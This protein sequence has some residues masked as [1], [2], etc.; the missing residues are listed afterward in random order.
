[1][2]FVLITPALMA[3]VLVDFILTIVLKVFDRLA[4]VPI[5][6]ALMSFVLIGI[7]RSGICYGGI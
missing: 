1:M 7:Y 3:F 2:T 4:F 5:T 6:I